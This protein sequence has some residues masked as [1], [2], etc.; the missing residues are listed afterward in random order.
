M[1]GSDRPGEGQERFVIR[2]CEPTDYDSV[3][4]VCARAE[5]PQ[6]ITRW[7]FDKRIKDGPDLFIVAEEDGRVVGAT[8]ATVGLR[9]GYV[10]LLAV[11]PNH[12]GHGVGSRLLQEICNRLKARGTGTIIVGMVPWGERRK[13]LDRFYKKHGFR[14]IGAIY[15]K[16][17]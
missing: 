6:V 9:I 16:R 8:I 14:A 13:Q 10:Y 12:Q 4:G 17:I 1:R 7:E 15:A 2:E 3:K 11:D 5:I